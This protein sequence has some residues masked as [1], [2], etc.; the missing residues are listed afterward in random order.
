MLRVLSLLALLSCDTPRTAGAPSSTTASTAM[1][2]P[3][4]TAPATTAPATTAPATT[5]SALQ[6]AAG[7]LAL[8]GAG[9]IAD[10]GNDNDDATARLVQAVLDQSP[11]ARAFTLGDNV[12]PDG[13]LEQFARCYEP[14]WGRFKARTIP[15]VGNHEYRTPRAAGFR[16]TFA[17]R[18]TADGPLWLSTDVEG[19][20]SD[21]APLRWHVIVLDSNCR[22]VGCAPGSPQHAFI[23]SD[24]RSKAAT[25]ADCTVALMHHPR[26]SSGHH[27][28]DEAVQPLWTALR[29]GGV[30]LVLAGHDHIYERFAPLDPAGARDDARGMVSLVVGT[31]GRSH[32][33]ALFAR[34]HSALRVTDAYGALLVLPKKGGAT[35]R[36]VGVDG[37]V[38]DEFDL[39]CR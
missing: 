14:T 15:V 24:L 36:F 5:R 31:G 16:G 38:H 17:G 19:T 13:T 29:D 20:G 10:C 33:P 22:E 9:D 6:I 28:D 35:V 11:A 7:Q 26:F 8:V 32:Y 21:G 1:A 4:T 37:A 34:A 18:F 39:R 12:Y 27:G 2:A 3:A 23:E 30:D 25:T